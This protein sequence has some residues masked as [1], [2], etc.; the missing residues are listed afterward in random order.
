MKPLSMKVLPIVLTFFMLIQSTPLMANENSRYGEY[1]NV[2]IYDYKLHDNLITTEKV[3]AYNGKD[4]QIVH[5]N[6][7]KNNNQYLILNVSITNQKSGYSDFKM[8]DIV[9]T[10]NNKEYKRLDNSFIENHGYEA[11]PYRDVNN[12]S[13]EGVIVF[14]VPNN[15]NTN[16]LSLDYQDIK[17]DINNF[18]KKDINMD[19]VKDTNIPEFLSLMEQQSK[20]RE[21]IA[22]TYDRKKY[23]FNDPLVIV[24]P[25]KV[26]PLT[27]LIMFDT[28]EEAEISVFIKGKDDFSNIEKTF[29]GYNTTH[30]IPILGLYSNKSNEVTLTMK[31]K[32]GVKTKKTLSVITENVDSNYRI[33]INSVNQEKMEEG[34]TFLPTHTYE[35]TIAIDSNGDIRWKINLSASHI[36][37]RLEDGNFLMYDEV[38]KN[39]KAGGQ[40][41]LIVS[42]LGEVITSYNIPYFIH[43]DVVV[44][45]NGNFLVTADDNS[46]YIEDFMVE[47]N[48]KT[49]K[50]VNEFSFRDVFPQSMID[51]YKKTNNSTDWFHQNAIWMDENS[52]IVSSRNQDITMKLSYPEFKIQWILSD[53]EGIDSSLEEFLLKPIGDVK[54]P[55]AQHAPMIMPDF[56]NNKDTIDLL[57]HDNNFVVTRGNRDLSEKYSRSVQYRIDEVNKTVEEIW[58]FGEELGESHFSIWMGDSDYL[59]NGNVLTTFAKE[60]RDTSVLET[61]HEEPAEIYFDIDL[62]G[63]KPSAA[64][65]RGERLSVY[66]DKLVT[67]IFNRDVKVFN[68]PESIKFKQVEELTTDI[69]SGS[70][71][72]VFIG[73]IS[74][75][76]DK[77][78]YIKGQDLADKSYIV[79]N[80]EE[81]YYQK[82]Y[83]LG[84]DSFEGKIDISNLPKG[85][86]K[87]GI[88]STDSKT[89]ELFYADS[90]YYIETKFTS[91]IAKESQDAVEKQLKKIYDNGAYPITSPLI[92]VDP[93]GVSPLTA[94]A[95]FETKQRSKVKVTVDGKDADTAISHTFD[96]LSYNHIIP[97]YGLY[98]DTENR[99]VFEIFNEDGTRDLYA[100]FVETEPVADEIY[101]VKMEKINEGQND[102]VLTFFEG[103]RNFAIDKNGDIRWFFGN[104]LIDG[105]TAS[106]IRLLN[107]GNIAILSGE[108][109]TFPY[110]T[111][112]LYEINYLGKIFKKYDILHGHHEIVELPN[113]NFL[114]PTKNPDRDTE[115]DYIVEIDRNTGEIV[116][117]I[118]LYEL[119]NLPKIA[120]ETYFI[121]ESIPNTKDENKTEQ[122][123]YE[124]ALDSA[125]HDWFHLNAIHYDNGNIVVSG[126][127]QD[128]VA[129]ID[130]E[131]EE[132]KWILSDPS[133]E[134]PDELKEKLLTPIGDNF[135]Y[136]YGQHTASYSNNMLVLYDNG[137]FRTKDAYNIVQ[138]EDNYSR[139]V[140]YKVDEENKTIE[141]V[142]QFGKG[143]DFFTFTP[144]IGDIDTLGNN[145][146]LINFGGMIIKDG[147]P[148]GDIFSGFMGTS[149]TYSRV[150]EV[151]DDEIIMNVIVMDEGY[152]NIFRASKEN[153]YQNQKELSFKVE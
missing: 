65:Y 92:K 144:Y 73:D 110:Y 137:N 125:R 57:I 55:G 138:P 126:R 106:P 122:E 10:D 26:A 119:F 123:N 79:F 153:I 42:P 75:A 1:W 17:V 15:I 107:N 117:S 41:L 145:H 9:L 3:V 71:N 108:I 120:D 13:Y 19:F 60:D 33:V 16:N 150:V 31:N 36:F 124:V 28:S 49:G 104:D 52:V 112:K 46:E 142:W 18:S 29:E 53:S 70:V 130:Y 34:L 51:D 115:E 6:Y 54:F 100:H 135:E 23:T 86:Y 58:S 11:I 43:H 56:D 116:K 91:N 152:S 88:M 98:A 74:I 102:G 77:I 4:S 63:N 149:D 80:G 147:K 48:S 22:N 50:I 78:I 25:F 67:D 62:F 131:T 118:D 146:Y 96:E 114:V 132:I 12:G 151:K 99:V 139:G 20:I 89:D 111:N 35:P 90:D 105:N 66:P 5:E 14:E 141:Q 38:E 21:D 72:K 84:A 82:L 47:I 44:L 68:E 143:L 95:M 87:I 7:P 61:S 83:D 30:Q 127:L 94:V 37:K 59:N 45:E 69:Y 40:R 27:A 76:K 81:N 8:K 97:I 103:T 136:S 93:Y 101:K 113:G 121:R 140:A 2:N 129:L 109:D 148:T 32:N 85:K 64:I 133:D 134:F 39:T 128:I 24:N